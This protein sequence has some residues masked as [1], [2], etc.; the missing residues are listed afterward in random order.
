MPADF[1]S[2][3]DGLD[4]QYECLE[5]LGQGMFGSVYRARCR[6]TGELVAIKRLLFEDEE[7][8]VPSSV[9]REVCLLRD[10]KH[11]NVVRLLQVHATEAQYSLVFEHIESDL[12]VA[13]KRVRRAREFLPMQTIRGYARDLTNGVAACHLR[14]IIHRDLKPSN[15]LVSPEGLKICDF[16]LARVF[17]P[18]VRSYT[19]DVITLW[20]RAPEILLGSMSYSTPVDVWSV[21]CCLFEIATLYALFP[22]NSEIGTIF[23]IFQRL[24]TPTKS[25]YKDLASLAHFSSSYPVWEPTDLTDAVREYRPEFLDEP[26]ADDF[27]DLVR[28]MLSMHPSE[29]MPAKRAK[30]HTFLR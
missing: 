27:M 23:L 15:V 4:E 16:G 14:M 12:H 9:I 21:G 7:D 5:I 25:T 2:D 13:L 3:G 28:A 24:G 11:P 1:A 10:F 20:Y 6:S 18:K 26:G 29:R 19:H 17:E 22:G 30:V 8:G